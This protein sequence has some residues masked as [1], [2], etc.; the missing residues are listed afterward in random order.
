MAMYVCMNISF[1]VANW[2][3]EAM[4]FFVEPSLAIIR[5]FI[6]WVMLYTGYDTEKHC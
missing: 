6:V 1:L 2:L 5:R 4:F 3:R